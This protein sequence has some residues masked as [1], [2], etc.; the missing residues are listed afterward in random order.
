M[1]V[2]HIAIG[3]SARPEVL[4]LNNTFPTDETI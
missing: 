3:H 4:E 1:K 2:Q